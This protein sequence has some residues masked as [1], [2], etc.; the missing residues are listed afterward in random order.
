MKTQ[1]IAILMLIA[2]TAS[3]CSRV[4][5][6]P[7]A[8]G[9]VLS[10]SGY[11]ADVK[12]PGKY[13]LAWWNSMVVLDTSTSTAKESITV[14]MADKLDLTFEVRFRSRIAGNDKTINTMF[15]DI[16]HQD[17]QVTLPMV[18]SIYGRDVV[19]AVGRSVMSKYTAEEVPENFDRIQQE[20]RVGLNEALKSSPLEMSNVT[21]G[22]ITYPK[23]ITEAI[24]AQAERR[25]AIETE[26]NQQA[27]EMVKKGNALELAKADYEIRM[28]KARAIR[29][30]NKTTSAGL[31]PMLLK[32]RALEVQ[33][34][35]AENSSAVFV[36]YDAMSDVGVSNRIYNK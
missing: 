4:T 36:P 26:Q 28:T 29:D 32:Y 20:L 24:E 7:A 27:I 9:K 33:E 1:K 3:A 31:S 5:V 25:L 15:N 17:Y 11:S 14:K 30:E 23:T 2:L 35:M 21:L 13:W 18:Y 12:E 22:S 34:K 8:K 6:P 19:R 10:A 16:K